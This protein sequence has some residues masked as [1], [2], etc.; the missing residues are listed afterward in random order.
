MRTRSVTIFLS[1][2][3]KDM[4]ND[5][6]LKLKGIRYDTFTKRISFPET[7]EETDLGKILDL[8][9]EGNDIIFSVASLR[10]NDKR[11]NQIKDILS[12]DKR[13]Y[14]N[15]LVR[16]PDIDEIVKL[17]LNLDPEQA[18]RFALLVNEDF[19]MTPYL[20]TSTSDAV[21]NM[22]ALS[23][24]YVKDFKEGKGTQ[25]LEK[26]DQIGKMIE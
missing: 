17:I 4:I 26:A 1:K 25:A 8:L 21:R 16:N 15:V 2:I 11:I 22:F 9:P 7:H 6:Y 10:Q 19:L 12:S 5:I 24:I 18:T 13:V 14:A 23:L 20:P 3:S